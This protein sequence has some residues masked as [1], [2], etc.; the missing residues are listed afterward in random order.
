MSQSKTVY[1]AGC[2][3]LCHHGHI[4]I[5]KKAKEFGDFLIVGVNSDSFVMSYK[6]L[7]NGT[8]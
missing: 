4:N 7:K 1:I 5:L 2:W 6:K 8:E 3:D